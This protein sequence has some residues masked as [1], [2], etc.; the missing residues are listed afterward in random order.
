MKYIQ[1][2]V[3]FILVSCTVP[4]EKISFEKVE[5]RKA[6][7]LQETFI[8]VPLEMDSKEDIVYISDF[9]GDSLLWCYNVSKR[10]LVGKMI[11]RGEGPGEFLSPIQFIL[12]DSM[13]FVHNRWHFTAQNY[14]YNSDN[15]TL[16][17][18]GSLI[19]FP[20]DIDMVY[21][22]SD[23]T[24]V[25]SG[26]F[27]DCRFVILDKNGNVISRCGNY[28]DY[29]QEEKDIPNFPKFMFHQSI[30]GFHKKMKRL[31]AVTSH[32]FE[33]WD[34]NSDSLLLQKRV[35]LSSYGYQYNVGNESASAVANDDVETGVKRIYTTDNYIY[36]LYDPNTTKM[37][38]DKEA[39]LNDEIW[40][41]DWEGVPIRK[42]KI[43]DK[44]ICFCVD[45]I[46][47]KIYCIMNAP[48]PSIG[49]IL[50]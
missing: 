41:F 49:V 44:L 43:N 31:A 42:I 11:A 24:Y 23:E 14:S 20:T 15:K 10:S 3:L 28:P 32:V 22:L 9:R 48:D 38:Y 36:M 8:G 37:Y 46:K 16:T 34:S 47:G 35:L 25:A 17:P 12:S 4:V 13:M 39:H 1:L 45:E 30:F 33:L 6:T 50:I 29:N 40:I 2:L 19:H 21:L 7:V 27:P 18:L 5:D 26:R